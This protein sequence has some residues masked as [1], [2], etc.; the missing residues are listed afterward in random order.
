MLIKPSPIVEIVE[1]DFGNIKLYLKRDDL[2]HPYISGNKWRKLKYN[3]IAAKA[4]NHHTLLT[5]GGA[6]SNHIYSTAAAGAEFNFKTIGII[7]GEPNENPT[8]NFAQ[9]CGMKLVFVDRATF[10]SIDAN[11][12]F[13]TLGI[14]EEVYFLPEGGTNQLA[15]KGCEEIVA[16]TLEQLG[17]TPDFFC[18]AAGTGGTASGIIRASKNI[19]QTLTFSV[20][21]GD[22]HQNEIEKLLQ[23]PYPNW[24]VNTAYHFGGYAKL[25]TELLDFINQFYEKHQIPLDLVYTGKLMYGIYDLIRKGYFPNNSRIVAIHTG[26]LQGNIGFKYRFGSDLIH[27]I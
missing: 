12:D 8:L 10:R 16:E 13:S 3:L 20:L 5:K 22:F 14:T 6:F 2:I 23:N 26:G 21:K 24:S 19:S 9:K 18:V 27:F 1:K 4:E 25:Q 17:F 15:L 11:F 7:R